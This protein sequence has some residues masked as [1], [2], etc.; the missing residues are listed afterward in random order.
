MWCCFFGQER[1]GKTRKERVWDISTHWRVK[2]PS[3]FLIN[4]S[5]FAKYRSWLN[6][7]L[8]LIRAAFFG[9]VHNYWHIIFSIKF[10]FS[11]KTNKPT[12]IKQQTPNVNDKHVFR[13]VYDYSCVMFSQVLILFSSTY[14]WFLYLITAWVARESIESPVD[15]SSYE[16]SVCDVL[17]ILLEKISSFLQI[18]F[19]LEKS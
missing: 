1:P 11:S 5:C 6:S 15:H 10:C 18:F 2:C 9:S 14:Q 17:I 19:L 3:P 4:M 12:P 7:F 16:I 13:Y 8:C